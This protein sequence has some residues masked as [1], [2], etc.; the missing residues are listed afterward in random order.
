MVEVMQGSR[1]T[2]G[3]G[4]ARHGQCRDTAEGMV[5]Q[6]SFCELG[7]CGGNLMNGSQGVGLAASEETQPKGLVKS[8]GQRVGVQDGTESEVQGHS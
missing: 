5:Q 7:E 1:G 2:L 4:F 8:P 3:Q 6:V